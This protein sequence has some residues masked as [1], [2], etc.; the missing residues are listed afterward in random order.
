MLEKRKIYLI[1]LGVGGLS[2]SLF[3]ACANQLDMGG[4]N[5]IGVKDVNIIN[6]NT[7]GE[8]NYA[9]NAKSVREYI[10]SLINSGAITGRSGG[11]G[12]TS[13]ACNGTPVHYQTIVYNGK[14]WLDRNLGA[15]QVA[16]AYNDSNGYGDLY[17]WGR[18]ADGHQCRNNSSVT[19]TLA[20]N[21]AN[22]GSS[23]I[24]V[25][26]DPFDWLATQSIGLWQPNGTGANEVCPTGYH[27]PTLEEWTAVAITDY[28]D[29]YSKLQLTAGGFRSAT[30]SNL[31][32]L[33][34]SGLY[35]SST[36]NASIIRTQYTRPTSASLN[37]DRAAR[38]LSVRCV[39]N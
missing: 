27:V 14:T 10:D 6:A 9:V 8:M 34:T 16:T 30:T 5:I 26:S 3:A 28:N 29:A 31:N 38:A 11:G 2:S 7:T 25:E 22:A 37:Y 24:Q 35:W 39:S 15:T 18:R 17:Q 12:Y 1:L 23:F 33:G 13:I 19:T 21:S 32:G 36:R 4:K 20:T